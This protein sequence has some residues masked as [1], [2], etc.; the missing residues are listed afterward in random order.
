MF[1]NRLHDVVRKLDELTEINVDD[2]ITANITADISG[3]TTISESMVVSIDDSDVQD[4]LDKIQNVKINSLTMEITN[5]T[6]TEGVLLSGT[7][8]FGA[9]TYT[10]TDLDLSAADSDNTKYDLTAQ[11]NLVQALSTSLKSGASATISLEGTV[12]D[13]P[14]K[15][16]VQVVADV[17][18]V[19]DVL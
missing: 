13:E 2:T 7:L 6:G 12:T 11:A 19:V 10:M 5:V 9:A 3:D 4:N 15:F 1:F 16:T 18:V 17:T 8:S 14:V